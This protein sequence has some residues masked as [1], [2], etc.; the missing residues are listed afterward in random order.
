MKILFT[1]DLH[2]RQHLYEEM[3]GYAL[4]NSCECI[5]IGGDLLPTRLAK[6][7]KLISGGVDFNESLSAQFAF[8][9]LYL[10]LV[11]GAFMQEH[12]HIRILYVPG[13]HDWKTAVGHLEQSLPGA[14]C[15]HGRI[16]SFDG[17]TFMGYGC[18]TD[19]PFWVKDYVRRDTSDSRYVSSRY[20]LV[21]TSNGISL[22]EK[23]SYA[24]DKPSIS[25]EL[26]ELHLK[27]P[28]N[29]ICIFHC[30][31]FGTGLDTL[32]NGTPI[33]SRSIAKYITSQQPMVS[34][35]GHIH[36]SPYMSGMFKTAL[37]RTLSINPGHHFRQLHAVCFDT[38]DPHATIT[39]RVFGTKSP[40]ESGM[41]RISDRFARSIKAFFMKTIL[42]KQ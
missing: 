24:L 18:V 7:I 41:D 32:H 29:T 36:E 38:S 1:C 42:I 6:P 30:P 15:M 19:S 13:N 12:P 35:H 14:L 31:P 40:K 11:L 25:E 17:I 9:D 34:L 8:I 21:S 22:S 23:G 5:L 39:H 27:D 33:G 2:G 26:S 4:E 28:H 16:E 3:F 20:P 10:A 37:G